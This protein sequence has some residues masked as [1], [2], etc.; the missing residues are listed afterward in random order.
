MGTVYDCVWG[1]DSVQSSHLKSL[2]KWSAFFLFLPDDYISYCIKNTLFSGHYLDSSDSCNTSCG[3]YG[4]SLWCFYIGFHHIGKVHLWLCTCMEEAGMCSYYWRESV[5]MFIETYKSTTQ[6]TAGGIFHL[7]QWQEEPQESTDRTTLAI[8]CFHSNLTLCFSPLS[9]SNCLFVL[10]IPLHPSTLNVQL[11]SFSVILP[12]SFIIIF[13]PSLSCLKTTH[14]S[15]QILSLF[16]IFH[17]STVYLPFELAIK[18]SPISIIIYLWQLGR[19]LCVEIC[20]STVCEGC[21]CTDKHWVNVM[22]G[23]CSIGKWQKKRQEDFNRKG[24]MHDHMFSW[25]I[26]KEGEKICIKE[27]K[28]KWNALKKRCCM[29]NKKGRDV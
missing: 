10:F 3:K 29:R 26:Q 5:R 24:W 7:W 13:S 16:P 14:P 12:I 27:R 19:A 17:H 9:H 18:I 6:H 21:V 1:L 20:R 15:L 23:W 28:Y 2:H 22:K 8:A 11:L 4:L 25:H